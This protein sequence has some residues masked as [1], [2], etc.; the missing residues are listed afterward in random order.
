MP[1]VFVIGGYH[2]YFWSNEGVPLEPIHVHIC[3]GTPQADATK[4][5]ITKDHKV[6]LCHNKSNISERNLK[7]IMAFIETNVDMVI[8]KWLFYFHAISYIQ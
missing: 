8:S 7:H 4:V 6:R 2:V 5:W 3:E 1:N